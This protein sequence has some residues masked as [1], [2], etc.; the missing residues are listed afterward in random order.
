[1]NRENNSEYRI[2]SSESEKRYLKDLLHR[3]LRKP[4]KL[5]A[6]YRIALKRLEHQRGIEIIKYSLTRWRKSTIKETQKSSCLS[7]QV[8]VRSVKNAC[9]TN[10]LTVNYR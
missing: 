1:M 9:Q 2:R 6:N 8:Y 4:N 5:S 3:R 7:Q 10:I